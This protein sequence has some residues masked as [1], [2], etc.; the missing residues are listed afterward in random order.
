MTKATLRRGLQAF[1]KEDGGA[2]V[3][4]YGLIGAAT[5]SVIAA[6]MVPVQESPLWEIFTLISD[7]INE[8]TNR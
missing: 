2:T 7:T 5:G 8:V 4:E 3:I 1:L 6:A